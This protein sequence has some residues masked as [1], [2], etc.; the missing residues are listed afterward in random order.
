MKVLLE[1]SY[2]LPPGGDTGCSVKLLQR[3]IGVEDWE[4]PDYIL[5]SRSDWCDYEQYQMFNNMQPAEMIRIA[6]AAMDTLWNKSQ[7]VCWQADGDT[8]NVPVDWSV[9]TMKYGTS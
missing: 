7:R 3:D 9:L 8:D 1:E 2:F 6:I 4:V 5:V